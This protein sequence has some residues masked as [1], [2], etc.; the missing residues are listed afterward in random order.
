MNGTHRFLILKH[1]TDHPHFDLKL[2]FGDLMKS[3]ILPSRI[4]GECG[5]KSLAIE[6]NDDAFNQDVFVKAMDD[7]Y[8]SGGAELWDRGYY[9]ILFN[10]NE[11]IT[12]NARGELF[13]GR[14]IFIVPSWGRWTGRRLWI[15]IKTDEQ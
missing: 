4:P 9:E 5:V 10:R 2:E 1:R 7:R 3:W 14:F 6:N 12:L 11:K 13:R 8:G 15:V